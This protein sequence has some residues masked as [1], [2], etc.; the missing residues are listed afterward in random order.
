MT[1]ARTIGLPLV[2][3]ASALLLGSVARADDP[4]VIPLEVQVGQSVAIGPPP[5]RNLICDD[6]GLVKPVDVGGA[7]ALLGL[8]AGTTLCSYTDSLSVRRTCRV[9]VRDPA[10]PR[11]AGSSAGPGQDR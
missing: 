11:G 10:S 4:A 6:A 9:T 3:A 7:P 5:I 2:L 8:A 1:P